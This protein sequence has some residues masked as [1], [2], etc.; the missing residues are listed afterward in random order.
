MR[1]GEIDFG[2]R[3]VSEL[4]IGL[5]YYFNGSTVVRLAWERLDPSDGPTDDA[6]ALMFA[7]GF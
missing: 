4:T 3:D 6:V 5:N 1:V 2:H 7:I